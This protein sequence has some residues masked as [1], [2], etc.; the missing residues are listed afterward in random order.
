MILKGTYE[1]VRDNAKNIDSAII[2]NRDFSYTASHILFSLTLPF[3]F[4]TPERSCLLRIDG[5]FAE[6]PQHM[7][8]RF[9]VGIQGSDLDR[10]IETYNFMSERYFTHT[11]LP[12]SSMP[13]HRTRN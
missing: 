4:K 5:R 7:I 2:Y 3:S 11:P 6:R 8:M 10:I 1:I 9:A 12:L 13:V